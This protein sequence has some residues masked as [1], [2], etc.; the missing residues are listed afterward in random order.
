[1]PKWA[2]PKVQKHCFIHQIS[3]DLVFFILY[4]NNGWIQTRSLK[5]YFHISLGLCQ[6]DS[7]NHGNPMAEQ[8][9]K[10]ISNRG[11]V[12]LYHTGTQGCRCRQADGN[13]EL[14]H[15]ETKH[16]AEKTWDIC[17]SN[18]RRSLPHSPGSGSWIQRC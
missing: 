18:I 7:S 10:I 5:S 4:C 12:C 13:I 14:L 9:I 1:M 11:I 8:V 17:V 3:S 2:V 15:M 16:D 6:K